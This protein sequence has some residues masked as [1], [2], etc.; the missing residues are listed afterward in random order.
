MCNK[1]FKKHCTNCRH[2]SW[3]DGDYT[4]IWKM[5]IIEES[6]NG[7]FWC[8]F[9]QPSQND[10]N[11]DKCLDYTWI[12]ENERIYE[13]PYQEFLKGLKENGDENLSF[14]EYFEKYYNRSIIEKEPT[15]E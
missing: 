1:E 5:K 14:Q 12:D 15:E 10:F 8:P 3:W 4:C 7:A 2:F 11:A 9:P 6:E 13:L